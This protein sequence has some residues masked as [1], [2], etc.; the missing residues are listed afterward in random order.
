[1]NFRRL[2]LALL[3]I[4]IVTG[5]S[6]S[7]LLCLFLFTPIGLIVSGLYLDR[8]NEQLHIEGINGSWLGRA[9]IHQIE[10]LSGSNK[11]T[12]NNIN[13]SLDPTC[14]FTL[15]VCFD[16]LQLQTVQLTDSVNQNKLSQVGVV[17]SNTEE[18]TQIHTI[19]PVVVRK[20]NISKIIKLD[21]GISNL[22]L[23]D[24][25]ANNLSWWGTK[26]KINQLSAKKDNDRFELQ[27]NIQLK[28]N[29][30]LTAQVILYPKKVA[31]N[32]LTHY[33]WR[34]ALKGAINKL[35]WQ[36]IPGNGFGLHGNGW[37][38]LVSNKLP[39]FAEINAE[40]TPTI[41]YKNAKINQINGQLIL[42]GELS[43]IDSINLEFYTNIN[44][45]DYEELHFKNVYMGASVTHKNKTIVINEGVLAKNITSNVRAQS[46][47]KINSK[48]YT[49]DAITF[50]GEVTYSDNISMQLQIA[51]SNFS[52]AE[53]VSFSDITM[54]GSLHAV[55]SFD[56]Q[57]S[58]IQF[59]NISLLVS[60]KNNAI[61]VSGNAAL[62][63]KQ[64][65]P[66]IQSKWNF[67]ELVV[68][69]GNDRLTLQGVYPEGKLAIN[70]SLDENKIFS[71]LPVFL[72][73]FPAI[74]G[75]VN[76]DIFYNSTAN[77]SLEGD[78]L[79]KNVTV[80]EVYIDQI[81]LKGT[82]GIA[83][84]TPLSIMLDIDNLQYQSRSIGSIQA[85]L[86][87]TTQ[88]PYISID[89]NKKDQGK[90]RLS[91]YSDNFQITDKSFWQCNEFIVHE[92]QEGSKWKLKAPF[93]FSIDRSLGLLAIDPFCMLL[94]EAG[95]LIIS[96]TG[97][98]DDKICLTN[99]VRV[100]VADGLQNVAI[101]AD[102]LAWAWLKPVLPDGLNPEGIWKLS[103]ND[104]SITRQGLLSATASFAS[105]DTQWLW[106]INKEQQV[107]F[108]T[109]A[110]KGELIIKES[111]I[112]GQWAVTTDKF[113]SLNITM[114]STKENKQWG[115]IFVDTNLSLIN[116]FYPIADNL[117]GDL[118]GDFSF[119]EKDEV[120]DLQGGFT[121]NNGILQ[122]EW[123][124]IDLT[125]IELK[126]HFSGEQLLLNG[127]Y[128]VGN[129]VGTVN[130]N[131]QI[132]DANLDGQLHFMAKDVRYE[133]MPDSWV[134][135]DPDLYLLFSDK[136]IKLEGKVY[137]DKGRLKVYKLPEQAVDISSDTII[138]GT[139]EYAAT[140]PF[141]MDINIVVREDVQFKGL[142]LETGMQ[143]DLRLWQNPGENFKGSGIVTL[144]NGSYK[145]YGQ[146]LLITSGKLIYTGDLYNPDV[147]ITAVRNNTP[148]HIV[149]GLRLFGELYAPN[150]E[151]FSQPAMS[152]QYKIH[153]LL[154]GQPPGSQTL[155]QKTLAQQTALSLGLALSNKRTEK[156]AS[157]FG[158][159]DF[160]IGTGRGVSG[161]EVQMGGQL[162]QKLHV[163]YGFEPSEQ[164]N[165]LTARYQ[166]SQN[167]FIELF[168]GTSSAIDLLWLI[169]K[170]NLA[171]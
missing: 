44:E 59:D 97:L 48:K 47:T 127:D 157:Q 119:T 63:N 171:Q 123:L 86:I 80:N 60:H 14:L 82:M 49:Q 57:E 163:R 140:W 6:V 137:V 126:G 88:T 69:S 166:I 101:E 151:L 160:Y 17:S 42:S 104:L 11:I 170:D 70:F 128:S 138:I 5:M 122:A 87:G 95:S 112:Q 155:D 90:T 79:A 91:C 149:V 52:L 158:I 78:I 153:Y 32:I 120:Q 62:T 162:S 89:W 106:R 152:E 143:G 25:A 144:K 98:Y 26:I 31:D 121:V 33:Q 109:P 39:F 61:N 161:Q 108:I 168:R 84:N 83:A 30:P 16:E 131:F 21:N 159:E 154:T 18:F 133:V 22:L 72:P 66:E 4:V 73:E 148:E 74:K 53:I 107:E 50:E 20:L 156:I 23:Q 102:N 38:N 34:F 58:N 135:G 100:S 111:A 92:L 29:F 115:V 28:K 139:E 129:S 142:G 54:T 55:A 51:A 96:S 7:F 118:N 85:A 37:V 19:I 2:M 116:T 147:S 110:I 13:F 169:S 114:Q 75:K 165:S 94:N 124:P 36:L 146:D 46:K 117:Q 81:A 3:K 10:W 77:K 68:R 167:F 43:D 24:I 64:D 45:L 8:V 99:T 56:L 12:I 145:A 71:F 136:S 15:S 67:D 76:G 93:D 65:Y 130:G 1:M 150:I 41:Q 113:G 132:N 103:V 40:N 35:R 105:V 27:G 141:E 9:T 134:L 164:V 125:N